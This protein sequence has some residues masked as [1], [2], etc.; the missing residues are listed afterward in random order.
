MAMHFGG[1]DVQSFTCQL[2]E[3]PV[4]AC[5]SPWPLTS[6][7]TGNHTFSVTPLSGG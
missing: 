4:E 3:Q 7:S 6:L 1:S 2:D 5:T